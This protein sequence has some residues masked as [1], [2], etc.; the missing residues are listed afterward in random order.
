MNYVF[1]DAYLFNKDQ[2]E[3]SSGFDRAKYYN[4]LYDDLTAEG[5]RFRKDFHL[6]EYWVPE[7]YCLY[8]DGEFWVVAFVDRGRR[9][10]PA[11][12]VHPEDAEMFFRA[13]LK[14]VLLENQEDEWSLP[15]AW[16]HHK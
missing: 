13:K 4:R 10:S 5:C 8:E 9:L 14:A 6:D 15:L 16:H 12:F 7:G 2:I 1:N 3:I 11:F